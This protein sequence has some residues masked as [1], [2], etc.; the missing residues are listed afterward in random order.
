MFLSIHYKYKVSHECAFTHKTPIYRKKP[1]HKLFS[2][3]KNAIYRG[4]VKGPGK[5]T[6]KA[7]MAVQIHS[8]ILQ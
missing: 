2:G 6:H 4:Q 5:Q 3:L 7:N 8:F 1:Q